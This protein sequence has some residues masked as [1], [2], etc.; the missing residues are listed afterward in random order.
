MNTAHHLR[1]RAMT[2]VEVLAVVVIL[3]LIAGLAVVG[4][5]GTFRQAKHETAKSQIAIITGKIE[6]YMISTSR[7]PSSSEGLGALTDAPPVAAHH[8]SEDAILDPW[9][10]TFLYVSPGPEG[11]PYEV[12]SLGEDGARGGEGPAADISSTS[13]RATG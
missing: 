9:G 13:L 2:L 3:G 5:S 12:I 4:F 8:L 1:R 10:R 11:H 6:A 7:H